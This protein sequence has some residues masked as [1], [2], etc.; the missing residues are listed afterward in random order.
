MIMA[1][2]KSQDLWP[3]ALETKGANGVSSSWRSKVRGNLRP[4]SF[5]SAESEFSL[6]QPFVLFRPSTSWMRPA[7]R[8]EGNRLYSVYQ[9]EC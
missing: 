6:A 4:S 9:C 5:P 1:T 3:K 7:N 8:E 2:E